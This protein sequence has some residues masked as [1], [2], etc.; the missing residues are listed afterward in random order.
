MFGTQCIRGT[1]AC[2]VSVTGSHYTIGQVHNVIAQLFLCVY[3]YIQLAGNLEA[4]SNAIESSKVI[5]QF[6]EETKKIN[7]GREK[8]VLTEE[9]LNARVRSVGAIEMS[10]L[11]FAYPS[12]PSKSILKNVSIRLLP[13]KFNAIVGSTGSG[14][15]TIVQLLLKNYDVQAGSIAIDGVN[16]AEI[17]AGWFR[18][19]IGY[20]DQEPTIF[21][22]SIRENIRVGNVDAIDE[23]IYDAL[24]KAKLYDFVA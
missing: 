6:I 20:V 13:N 16:L 21:S 18:E 8:E 4:I 11:H 2:P 12:N 17:D 19:K 22:G 9:K 1:S 5:Y 10:N 3:S 14:K 15:S 24:R 23:K 7:E